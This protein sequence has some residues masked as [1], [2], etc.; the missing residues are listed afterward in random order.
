MVASDPGLVPAARVR[1]RGSEHATEQMAGGPA[2]SRG[3]HRMLSFQLENHV[4][5][6]VDDDCDRLS[7][8]V[9]EVV[10]A[11]DGRPPTGAAGDAA[12]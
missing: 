5:R 6:A 12:G 11:V 9:L 1:A 3:G 8:F 4:L 10:A 2:D 7:A